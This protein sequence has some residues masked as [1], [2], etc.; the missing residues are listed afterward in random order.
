[1]PKTVEVNGRTVWLTKDGQPWSDAMGEDQIDWIANEGIRISRILEFLKGNLAD[2]PLARLVL[3][4]PP[5]SWPESTSARKVGGGSGAY[6]IHHDGHGTTRILIPIEIGVRIPIGPAAPPPPPPSASV[7]LPK[8]LDQRPLDPVVTEAVQIDTSNYAQR[9]GYNPAFLGNG[10]LSVPLPKLMPG[11]KRQMLKIRGTSGELKYWNYSVVMNA[12]RQLAFFSA[13]NIDP[14]LGKGKRSGDGWIRDSR[15]DAINPEAQLGNEFYKKQK[16]FEGTEDRSK[17]P[18]DQGHLTRREDLQWGRTDGIAKTNGDDSFHYPNCA[19][20]HFEFNQARKV[21]GIWNRLEQMTT[22]VAGDGAQFCVFNGPVFDAAPCVANGDGQLQL[23][24]G[25]RHVADPTFGGVQIPKQF[26]KVIV[27]PD[28]D[29][30]RVAAFVVTQE[31]LLAR[32]N[33]LRPAEAALLEAGLTDEEVR[34]YQVT[35]ADLSRM[36]SLDFGKLTRLTAVQPEEASLAPAFNVPIES[37][38]DI[39]F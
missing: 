35:L 20:Q 23:D 4:A 31:D 22:Q 19:P 33:R 10:P 21:N 6:D 34:L 30:L 1:V 28:D 32:V 15:V 24:P 26:F 25:G 27:W 13:A 9:N 29:Q 2:H 8:P 7:G 39:R 5:A 17:N 36:T 18:F 38:R 11:I 14:A 37:E 12:S 3:D 16:T